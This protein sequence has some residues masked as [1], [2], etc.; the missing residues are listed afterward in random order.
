[1][2]LDTAEQPTGWVDVYLIEGGRRVF[3]RRMARPSDDDELHV[4]HSDMCRELAPSPLTP[5]S[6]DQVILVTYP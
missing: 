4:I 1:M 2:M 5:L 6:L 3:K